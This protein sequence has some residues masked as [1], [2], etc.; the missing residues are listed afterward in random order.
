MP[1]KKKKPPVAILPN[2]NDEKRYH[3]PARDTQGHSVRVQFHLPPVM[4]AQIQKIISSKMTPLRKNGDLYRVGAYH[5]IK[6]IERLE[7]P[8]PSVTIRVDAILDI[9][10]DDEMANDFGLVFTKLATRIADHMGHGATGEAARLALTV[11]RQILQMPEGYW[12]DR[13]IE[14][15]KERFGY[16]VDNTRKASLINFEKEK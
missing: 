15:F 6:E 3:V 16:L 11:K 13:Y 2:K 7:G 14:E 5:L 12:R 9:V 4:L 1:T 10:R 8:I